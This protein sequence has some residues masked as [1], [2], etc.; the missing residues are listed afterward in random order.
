MSLEY[1]NWDVAETL[2]EGG[3]TN[4]GHKDEEGKTIFEIL[5]DEDRAR[6]EKLVEEHGADNT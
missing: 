1:T 4:F 5:D 2:I 6:L 3:F